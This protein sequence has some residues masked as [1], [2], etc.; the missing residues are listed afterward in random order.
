M[1]QLSSP[2][3][4]IYRRDLPVA[5][6][7]ILDPTDATAVEQGEWLALD[8]TGHL[9]R[10]G[11]AP[12]PMA[13]QVFTQRGDYSSQAISKTCVLQ[14]H[15]YEGE[16]DMFEDAGGGFAVNDML[17]VHTITVDGVTR[18]GFI[19]AV[20]GGTDWVYAIV[21]KDPAANNGRLGFMTVSPYNLP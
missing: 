20:A 17:T 10:V 21:T 4:D 1:L 15:E 14:L 11:A 2:V 8:A 7:T 19:Q 3:N 5:D 16:T 12:L 13:M 6:P 18:S 9:V